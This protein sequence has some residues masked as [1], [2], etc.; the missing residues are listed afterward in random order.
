M[1]THVKS[2]ESFNKEESLRFSVR[3]EKEKEYTILERI[4]NRKYLIGFI[5][6]LSFFR[7]R[8]YST[9]FEWPL[10]QSTK[11]NAG[12]KIKINKTSPI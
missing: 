11:Q 3:L 4:W 8:Y 5:L 9:K 7:N 12:L 1:S 6:A 10:L 2:Y